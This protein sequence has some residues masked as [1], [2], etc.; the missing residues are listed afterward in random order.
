MTKSQQ[1]G[2][3]VAK[4]AYIQLTTPAQRATFSAITGSFAG[5]VSAITGL[6]GAV[7]FVPALSRL[8]F[9]AK[10]IIGTT[11]AAVTGATAAGSLAYAQKGVTDLPCAITV[12]F[13]GACST[14]IGQQF[15]K[16]I[17]GPQMRRMLGGAL[18]LCAPSVLI[19][20]TKDDTYEPTEQEIKEK[21]R[22]RKALLDNGIMS[23][24][25]DSEGHFQQP[26]GNVYEIVRQQF[27]ERYYKHN[28]NWF[29]VLYN[30]REYVYLGIAVGLIQGTVGI[31][32]GVLVTSYLSAETDMEVHRIAAT[33]LMCTLLTNIAV[34][35]QHYAA[36]NI[37]LRTASILAGCAMGC[38]YFTARNIA[39]DIPE[40]GVRAFIASALLA[41]GVSMLK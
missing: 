2:R 24:A 20:K 26:T 9:N 8:G 13:A 4:K 30:E 32:G 38:S 36:G 15:A 31:G 35:A 10:D 7:V 23:S 6:G 21:E 11:V 37:K 3:E 27:M 17:S 22:I 19:K 41:S 5:M 39:L 16:H 40:T 12:G 29:D 28:G 25:P 1:I 18:I 14:P 34:G 33:A